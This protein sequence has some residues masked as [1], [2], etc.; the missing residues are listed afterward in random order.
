MVTVEGVPA[1]AATLEVLLYGPPA[2]V[3]YWQRRVTAASGMTLT[4]ME[5]LVG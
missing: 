5:L 3:L 2:V 4:V 1:A